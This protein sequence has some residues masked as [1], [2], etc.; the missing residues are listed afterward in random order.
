MSNTK[1]AIVRLTAGI[2][3]VPRRWYAA[4][5]RLVRPRPPVDAVGHG[6]R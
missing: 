4:V 1:R 5:D 2:R 6:E 3:S